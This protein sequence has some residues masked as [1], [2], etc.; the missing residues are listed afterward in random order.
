MRPRIL[1]VEDD[2]YFSGILRDYLEYV[3]YD[4]QVVHDGE[5]GLAAFASDPPHVL[6]TEVLLPRRNGLELSAA[7]KSQA[8]QVA[9]ML[10]SA[11]YK[12]ADGIAANLK[13]C[14]ADD[15]LIK[16]FAMAELREKLSRLSTLGDADTES[17]ASLE[18][19]QYQPRLAL[20]REGIVTPGFLADLMLSIRAAAHTGVLSIR[21]QSRH[22]DIVFLKGRPVWAD[23]AAHADRLGTMLLEN[24]TLN[25]SQ[26]EVAV[27]SMKERGIDFGSGLTEH[28]FLTA[29]QLYTELR[30]LVLRRVILAFGWS[31]GE[32]T[33]GSVFPRQSS[34]FEVAPLVAIF[35]GLLAHR[36]RS[37]IAAE[38]SAHEARYVIPSRR[39][40]VDWGE[41]KADP[42]VGGLGPFMTGTRTVAQLRAFEVVEPELLD[43]ALFVLFH[44]GSIGFGEAPVADLMPEDSIVLPMGIGA[45][46]SLMDVAERVICD[47]LQHWQKD[48]F[49][50]YGLDQDADDV[51]VDVALQ[52]DVLAWEP[53]GLPDNL[54]A[55]L[56]S[57]AK[58]LHAWVG[59]A[60]ST[61][62]DMTKRGAYRARLDQGLTG[63]YRKVEKPGTAEAAMF[64]Q[65]GKG[66]IR[67]R[68]FVEAEGAFQRAS[69]RVPDSGEYLAYL[70]YAVYRRSGGN[71]VAADSALE[72]LNAALALDPHSGMA[73][74]FVGVIGRDQKDYRSAKEAFGKSVA[75]DPSF[76]PAARSLSQVQDLIGGLGGPLRRR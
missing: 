74:F 54:T 53:E 62:D 76:E 24:G 75:Y 33:L 6:L 4:V 15:Y 1:V 55:E 20:P 5:D 18:V 64:F 38:I 65:L 48:Y 58:A 29:T 31:V 59:A 34:S 60:H 27:A 52:N 2:R 42:D 14:G 16:P 3:G 49:A 47:Y 37:V 13:Q 32:W 8:P 61:L 28:G 63:F 51:S 17:D 30:A 45:D 46:Q 21:D 35:R 19:M 22:K 41:L 26:V 68:N 67:A 71:P 73:W 9:V 11:V 10:M 69:E 66:F 23:G 50:I 39:F 36:D 12:D 25:R 72:K 43:A 57:K 44:A 7:A 70:G 56:R 40:A